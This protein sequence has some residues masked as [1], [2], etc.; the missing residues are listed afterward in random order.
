MRAGGGAKADEGE[1]GLVSRALYRGAAGEG[2]F[3]I[4]R[5]QQNRREFA[6]WDFAK[7]SA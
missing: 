1:R 7:S 3:D 4:Y 5:K 6:D 2:K